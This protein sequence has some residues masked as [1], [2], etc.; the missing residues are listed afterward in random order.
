MS[1]PLDL[2][3]RVQVYLAERR[4]LGFGMRCPSQALPSF[5]RFVEAS[6]HSGPLSVELMTQWARQARGGNPST[7]TV[8]RKLASLR[9]FL[10]W[11]QQFDPRTEVPD[12]ASFGPIPGRV[13]PHIYQLAEILALLQA[14]HQLGSI[15]ALRSATYETLFG[16]MASTGLRISEAL[17]L[18]DHDVD[19]EA[20][21]L[22]IRQTKFCKSRLVPV[23]PSAVA[24]LAAYRAL[25]SQLVGTPVLGSFFVGSRG[26]RRGLP[27][28]NRQVAR[29][30]MQLRDQLGWVDRGGHGRPRVHD[31]RHSFA[32]RRL[33]LWHEQGGDL[34]Q[35]MLALSTYMGHVKISYTYWYL[36]GTPELMA[37]AGARFERF[38]D[39]QCV[40][41]PQDV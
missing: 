34:D 4:S 33:T 13:S 22:T 21:V 19:L 18:S 12:D 3:G 25:R 17:R 10:G 29:T 9:P 28:G 36:T 23:H 14:A 8:A 11:L 35:R 27:L 24:P 38:A 41:E 30:F 2:A 39:S 32:V 37:L 31:L 1:A 5:A 16:L 26:Q 40:Q 15:D 6:Q 7:V 20:G